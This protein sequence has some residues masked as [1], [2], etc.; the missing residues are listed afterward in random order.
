MLAL[1]AF[2]GVFSQAFAC[3]SAPFTARDGGNKAV[4]R[5]QGARILSSGWVVYSRGEDESYTITRY[6]HGSSKTSLWL[7][8]A[9]SPS[10]QPGIVWGVWRD[11]GM[12]EGFVNRYQIRTNLRSIGNGKEARMTR[13]PNSGAFTVHCG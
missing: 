10:H 13:D 3:P 5:I 7:Y 11:A 8:Q 1:V 6:K 9:K 4:A 2:L 12:I